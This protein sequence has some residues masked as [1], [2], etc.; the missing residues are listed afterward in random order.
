MEQLLTILRD[1][2]DP[3][4]L[5]ARHDCAA[6]IFVAL[7]ASLC[8]A[9]SSVDIADFAAVNLTELAEIVDLAHGAPSHDSF[10]RL[11]RL[12]EP[13]ELEKSLKA[14]G[15]ALREGLGLGP[16]PGHV[17]I[18]GKRLRRGYERGRAHMPPLMLNIIDTQTRLSLAAHAAPDGNEFAAALRA[19]N[20][21]DLKGCIVSGDALYGQPSAAKAIRGRGGHYVLKLKANNRLLYKCAVRTFAEADKAGPLAVF[22]QS[23]TPGRAVHD[24]FECRRGSVVAPPADAPAMPGLVLFGRIERERRLRNGKRSQHTQYVILSKRMTAA[25]MM[26][27]TRDHWQIENGLHWQLD[28]VFDEDDARTRKDHGPH[29]LSIIRQF[30]LSILRAHPDKRSISRKMKHAAWSKEYFLDLFTHMR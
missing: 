30:A 28:V 7:M 3:R 11:F 24:R 1:V 16:M 23:S 6:M 14:F 25:R 8:G 10:S 15:Q 29:N 20:S 12:L 19:L 9:K 27:I 5:N 26:Q 4:D 13:A 18:D 17:A 22:E 2:C 21:L